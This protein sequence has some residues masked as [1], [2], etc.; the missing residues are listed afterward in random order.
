MK[1]QKK[2]FYSAYQIDDADFSFRVDEL[3]LNNIN[4]FLPSYREPSFAKTDIDPMLPI[5]VWQ[6]IIV[7]R[8]EVAEILRQR[9]LRRR[10]K[11]AEVIK[12]IERKLGIC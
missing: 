8:K 6:E 5:Q 10:A 3:W 9:E 1:V 2:I 4:R 12:K 7:S 11:V